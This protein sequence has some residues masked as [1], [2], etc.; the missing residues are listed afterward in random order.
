MMAA[1]YLGQE[2]GR[3]SDEDVGLHRRVLRAVGLPTAIDC[4]F[5]ALERAWR[6][7]KKYRGGVRFVIL[8]R[9]GRAQAGIAPPR[10]ALERAVERLRA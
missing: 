8:D 1:A 10:P 4:D 2:L 3:L 6:H 9:I 7:D 5:E